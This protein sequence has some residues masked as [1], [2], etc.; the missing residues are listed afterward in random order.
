MG[1]YTT[2]C[3]GKV[4]FESICVAF[5]RGHVFKLIRSCFLGCFF[6]AVSFIAYGQLAIAV[7]LFF[8]E[9]NKQN[10]YQ[11]EGSHKRNV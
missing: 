2:E 8:K 7:K 5:S 1:S 3:D 6:M 4:S 10:P 9:T 11:R